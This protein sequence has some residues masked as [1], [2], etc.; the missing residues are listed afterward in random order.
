MKLIIDSGATKTQWTVLSGDEVVRSLFTP[1][2]NPYYMDRA[3]IDLLL[4]K[5]LDQ[6]MRALPIHR[7]FYFGTGCSTAENCQLIS[8]ILS[9]YFEKASI[10][11]HHDLTGAAVSL[12]HERQGIACILGTGSNSCLWDGHSIVENVPSLGYLLG[13]EGSG[14]YLGKLMLKSFLSGDAGKSLTEAFYRFTALDFTGILHKIYK[15]PQA[16]R[17][18]AGLSKFA[19]QHIHEPFIEKLVKQNFQDFVDRQATKYT[20]HQHLEISFVG[21]VAYHFQKQLKEVLDTNRLKF[22][23][24]F[25]APMEG[26]IEY[27][28]QPE[29]ESSNR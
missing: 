25:Q 18:I 17:W 2:I 20:N 11:M 19:G 7:V 10:S 1:G 24:V 8:G 26:L 28:K 27:Y 21:S 3:Q 14:T 13:D 29:N 4:Q 9:R 23:K 6:P 16:N 22:G 15:D 12:F 5:H